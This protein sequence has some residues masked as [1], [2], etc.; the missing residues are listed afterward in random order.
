LSAFWKP[1]RSRLLRKL[2]SLGNHAVSDDVS[3][4]LPALPALGP[5]PELGVAPG[6]CGLALGADAPNKSADVN[7]VS[8]MRAF[9]APNLTHQLAI[10]HEKN[11]SSPLPNS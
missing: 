10:M 3:V 4:P 7:F 8:T 9:H 6:G 2:F 1:R 5:S 11:Q